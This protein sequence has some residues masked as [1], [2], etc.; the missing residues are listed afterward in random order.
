MQEP[1]R[2]IF[3]FESK[4]KHLLVLILDFARIRPFSGVYFMGKNKIE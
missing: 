2:K 1:F 4:E 3:F